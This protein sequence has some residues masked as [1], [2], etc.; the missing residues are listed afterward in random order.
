MAHDIAVEPF[1]PRDAGAVAEVRRAAVPYMVCTAESVAWEARSAPRAAHVRWLV[2]RD[3]GGRVVGCADT[4][5]LFDSPEPGQG[6]LHTA[7]RP[8]ATGLGAGSA[9]AQEAER[10]LSGLGASCVWTWAADDDR[11]A[12]F[13]ERRGYRRGRRACFLGLDLARAELPESPGPLP[14]GV[15]LRTA[16]DFAD[17]R[18][19]LYEA[20]VECTADE[21]GDVEHGFVPYEDWLRLKWERPDLD[22]RLGSVVLVGGEVAAYSMAQTDGRERYWSA[23]T[24]TRRAH[25]GRGLARVAKVDSLLRARAAGLT[26]AFTGNDAANAPMLALNRRLGYAQAAAE[27]RYSK[28]L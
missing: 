23:M 12:G 14:D 6:Y 16:W 24:G 13:A 15:E 27:W 7:V 4:G 11:S 19:P 8:E 22:H 25:R 21:P 20:D 18:R 3:S 2:A 28:R 17:D 10:Y 5:L 9:L 1:D 26:R